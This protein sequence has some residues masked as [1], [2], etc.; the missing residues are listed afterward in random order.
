VQENG[1][2]PDIVVPQLSDPRVADRKPVREADLKKHLINEVKDSTNLLVEQD[3]APDP[4]FLAK[5]DELK[6]KGVLDYQLDYALRLLSRL[7]PSPAAPMQVA[8]AATSTGTN[9]QVRP[10]GS[11]SR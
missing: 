8:N 1:I 4:R 7:A 10:V 11:P 2:D 6:A 9:G 5:A 3:T